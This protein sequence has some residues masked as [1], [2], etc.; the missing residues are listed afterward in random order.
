MFAVNDIVKISENIHK[1]NELEEGH[2]EW[3]EAMNMVRMCRAKKE[4]YFA[5]FFSVLKQIFAIYS[6][7][8]IKNLL[9]FIYMKNMN[10]FL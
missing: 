2:S 3:T 1:V 10:L 6:K 8:S 4:P 5:T 7:L 9:E